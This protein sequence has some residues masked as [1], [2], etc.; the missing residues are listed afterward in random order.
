MA[1]FLTPLPTIER[2]EQAQNN[3]TVR[4]VALRNK[5]KSPIVGNIRNIGAHKHAFKITA[6]LSCVIAVSTLASGR[7][8]LWSWKT[9][10]QTRLLR[11]TSKERN[12][13]LIHIAMCKTSATKPQ[14]V[15][16]NALP[17]SVYVFK[18]GVFHQISKH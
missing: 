6:L 18:G 8:R 14:V 17:Q 12:A 2:L 10:F 15:D 13:I 5:P 3:Y 7:T 1:V 11:D 9:L 16:N 4:L